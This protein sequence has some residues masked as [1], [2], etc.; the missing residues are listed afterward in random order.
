MTRVASF[1]C[2]T[3]GTGPKRA[4]WLKPQCASQADQPGPDPA[5]AKAQSLNPALGIWA[6]L[7]QQLRL[8]LCNLRNGGVMMFRL[9]CK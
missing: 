5:L 3:K 1:S 4:T 9:N 6:L 8:G 7:F 2:I